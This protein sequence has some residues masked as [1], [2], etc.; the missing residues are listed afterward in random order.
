MVRADVELG[1]SEQLFNLLIGRDMQE[2]TGQAPQVVMTLPLLEGTD[3]VNK[4]SKSLGNYISV[5]DTPSDMF[6]KTMGISDTLMAR[7]YPLLLNEKLDASLHPMEAKK[8]LAERLV[9]RFHNATAARQAR[10][11]FEKVFSQHQLP[12]EMPSFTL[13]ESP[14]PLMKLLQEIKAAPSGSEAR[15]LITQGG[16]TVGGEKIIDPMAPID[17]KTEKVVKCG[18]RFFAKVKA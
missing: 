18:K 10:E 16:V 13:S 12:E 3:G 11:G 4:M 9:T 2:Q 5:N 1:G 14:L 15:R 7:W 8:Q 17:C 6:G